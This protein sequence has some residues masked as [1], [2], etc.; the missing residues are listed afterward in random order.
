MLRPLSVVL[1]L[2]ATLQLCAPSVSQSRSVSVFVLAGQSNMEGKAQN[3][4]WESQAVAADTA[5]FFAPFRNAKNTD[6]VIR[7]DVFI[8]FLGRHGPLT[9]GFGSPGRTGLEYAFGLRIGDA[10]DE[11]VLLIKA[12]W[13]G[14]SIRKDFRPPS[15]G[16]PPKKELALEL[17]EAQKRVRQR[18][19][20]KQR[21]DPLPTMEDI[22]K[23]YGKDYRA[24]MAEITDAMNSCG[25]LF[26]ELKGKKLKLRG[27]VW[28]QGWNDQYGGAEN[29]YAKNMEHFI[30][31]VRADLGV[32][33]LPF[34]V[35]VMG[36]NGKQPA[37]GAMVAIQKAQKQMEKVSGFRGNVR[38]VATAKLQDEV[39]ARVYPG[40]RDHMDEWQKVG[41]DHP[42]HYL[43][44]AI[45]F[46]RIGFGMADAMLAMKPLR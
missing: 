38:A 16:M 24:M 18:N 11:P 28:F 7:D 10:I 45:W 1:G 31:D 8:K 6:W 13:G 14:R 36:Q 27:F 5:E 41:S 44:S 15:A 37:K 34:V 26:P 35:G 39:A 30:T 17:E 9:L 25:K 32:E 19:E 20:K 12:A 46:S 3:V 2:L 43:G 4:L 42:Y 40:W 22:T 21:T 29:E 23:A 33:G